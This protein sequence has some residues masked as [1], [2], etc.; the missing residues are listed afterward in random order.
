MLPPFWAGHPAIATRNVDE[1][2]LGITYAKHHT[3]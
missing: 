2:P 3:Y 1:P